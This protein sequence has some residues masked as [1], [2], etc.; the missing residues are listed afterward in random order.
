M[1]ILIFKS[2]ISGKITPHFRY[3]YPF[4]KTLKLLVLYCLLFESLEVNH[5]PSIDHE[6]EYMILKTQKMNP[7]TS[8][9]Y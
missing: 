8:L 6:E 2:D 1:L 9:K 4:A 5:N 7:I 3:L